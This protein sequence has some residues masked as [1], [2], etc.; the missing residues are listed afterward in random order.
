MIMYIATT[1]TWEVGVL[2]AARRDDRSSG[3]A[4]K[5]RAWALGA[6]IAAIPGL[7]FFF[8]RHKVERV[9]GGG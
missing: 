2:I 3:R 6:L 4:F 7:V 5:L 9:P 8:I 1:I